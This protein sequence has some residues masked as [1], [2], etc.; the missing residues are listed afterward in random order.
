MTLPSTEETTG[1][2]VIVLETDKY[3]NVFAG[4]TEVHLFGCHLQQQEEGKK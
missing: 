4:F 2:T 1:V 3:V